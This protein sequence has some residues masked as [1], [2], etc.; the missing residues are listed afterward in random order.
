MAD[1]LLLTEKLAQY[2]IVVVIK[3]DYVFTLYMINDTQFLTQNCIPY[4]VLKLATEA[5]PDKPNIEI[6]KN[7]ENYLLLVLKPESCKRITNEQ[8]T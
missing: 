1:L 6:F 7:E 8:T 4:Q 2:G 5:I 3:N